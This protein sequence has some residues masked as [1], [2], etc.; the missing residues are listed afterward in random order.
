MLQAIK[1]NNFLREGYVCTILVSQDQ[2]HYLPSPSMMH[3]TW[4]FFSFTSYDYHLDPAMSFK[5]PK[6]DL[7]L[8]FV[9]CQ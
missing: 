4:I 2:Y 8:S 7:Q 3:L 6:T 1:G 5:E 9:H